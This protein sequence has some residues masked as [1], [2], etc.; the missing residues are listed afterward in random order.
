MKRIL[1]VITA[2]AAVATA[3]AWFAAQESYVTTV[4][5][6]IGTS[7]NVSSHGSQNYGLLFGQ[8]VRRGSMNVRINDKAAADS[9]LTS[10]DYQVGCND[11]PAGEFSGSICPNLT[12]GICFPDDFCS[13]N[14]GTFRLK[15][16]VFQRVEQTI[17][18]TFVAPDCVD[19]AQKKD[20]PKTVNCSQDQ[21]YTLSGQIFIDVVNR[22]I[23]LIKDQIC[24]KKTGVFVSATT[25]LPFLVFDQEVECELG[26]VFNPC[27]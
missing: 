10:V 18:W 2:I 9:N 26:D 7:L 11:G 24:D 17:G 4:T 22:G 6:N 19:A 16:G 20:N 5:A 13:E 8:E 21:N 25:G 27:V 12:V 15:V 14:F 23:S 1:L 3:A